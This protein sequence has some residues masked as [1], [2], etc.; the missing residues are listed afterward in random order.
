[1]RLRRKRQKH[2][3]WWR[4]CTNYCSI[5]HPHHNSPQSNNCE[6]ACKLLYEQREQYSPSYLEDIS[7]WVACLSKSISFPAIAD[8]AQREVPG[9]SLVGG[10]RVGGRCS[11]VVGLGSQSQRCRR[12]DRRYMTKYLGLD[13]RCDRICSGARWGLC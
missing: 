8:R 5:V 6:Q 11:F 3:P 2:S 10:W 7:V 9:F 13:G 12:C 1:M 4:T